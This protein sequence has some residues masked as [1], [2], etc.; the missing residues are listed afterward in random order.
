MDHINAVGDVAAAE[1]I[2]T[3]YAN[4]VLLNSA[5]EPSIENEVCETLALMGQT[6]GPFQ[7]Y[8]GHSGV[9]IKSIW[10]QETILSEPTV[11]E[12]DKSEVLL[13]EYAGRKILLCG[14]I[15]RIAQ[16]RLIKCNPDLTVDV[17]ILPHHGSTTNLDAR[18]VESLKPTIVIASCSKRSISNAYHPPKGASI[19]AFYTASDGAVTVKIKSDG[20]LDAN[21]FLKAAKK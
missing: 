10:P 13:I 9:T 12:N 5:Q 17:L 15:E 18:F 21:G 14:D 20:N 6:V 4:Q 16:N 3:I 11:S 19:Q 1:K 2:D 7:A 8:S